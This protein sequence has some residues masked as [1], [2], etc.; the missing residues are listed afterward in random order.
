MAKGARKKTKWVSLSLVSATATTI[1]ATENETDDKLKS[2]R[3]RKTYTAVVSGNSAASYFVA[4]SSDFGYTASKDDTH[5]DEESCD[6]RSQKEFEGSSNTSYS[7]CGRNPYY[8]KSRYLKNNYNNYHSSVK[9]YYIGSSSYIRNNSYSCQRIADAKNDQNESVRINE[10]EYT[11]ITT[12][13][14]DVLFKKGYLSRPKRYTTMNE[15]STLASSAFANGTTDGSDTATGSGSVST[16]ESVISDITYL[17]EG[18]F[19]EYP[20]PY[21]YFGYFD[22]SG[23]LVMNGFAVDNHGYSYMNGGQTYI[24]PPN[25]HCTA[26]FDDA[27]LVDDKHDKM[28][29][30]QVD[31]T[32][33][34]AKETQPV[35]VSNTSN[36]SN[37]IADVDL[38]ENV[39]TNIEYNDPSS[40]PNDEISLVS[41]EYRNE[42]NVDVKE[43]IY[44]TLEPT[45]PQIS[46]ISPYGNGYDYA[47]FYNAFYYPGCV[48]APFPIV[49]D[50]M[51]YDQVGVLSEEEYA[52]QSSFKKRKKLC[53]NWEEYPMEIHESEMM[54]SGCSSAEFCNLE[55]DM[56]SVVEVP[57]NDVA[58]ESYSVLLH[59]SSK[60]IIVQDT[61]PIHTQSVQSQAPPPKISSEYQPSKLE[62]SEDLSQ[63]S[64]PST[65]VS[66]KAR[67][68][69]HPQKLRKRDLIESTLTFAEQNIDLT[70][71]VSRESGASKLTAVRQDSSSL[72]RTVRKGKE[73]VVEEDL[74]LRFIDTSAMTKMEAIH[75]IPEASSKD[76]R[77][78]DVIN[79]AEFSLS[80]IT[81]KRD[82]RGESIGKKVKKTA[83]G[84]GKKQKK[85]HLL[86]Q[87]AGF[88]VIEPKFSAPL[89]N[90]A[91]LNAKS[92][93][94]GELDSTEKIVL[95][96]QINEVNSFLS[97]DEG[98]LALSTHE[99]E[100]TDEVN[101]FSSTTEEHNILRNNVFELIIG[102]DTIA[103]L[104][105]GIFNVQ[106]EDICVLPDDSCQ[107]D[108]PQL[109]CVVDNESCSPSDA[110]KT[111]T[112]KISKS[113]Q[114]SKTM[115][116]V[117]SFLKP[118]QNESK[119]N[120]SGLEEN[121][122][123]NSTLLE[124]SN[125]PIPSDT[126]D[127]DIAYQ[128]D[129][130]VVD[131]HDCKHFSE[132]SYSENYDSG[133][134][135]PTTCIVS[136]NI[137]EER[138]EPSSS[139]SDNDTNLTEAVIN[140]LSE[141]LRN[142]R[143]DEMFVLPEDPTLLHR[144]HQFNVMNSDDSL[145][146]SSDTYSSTSADETEDADSD[147]MSDVQI[148][149][150]LGCN[151][152]VYED[153]QKTE[154]QKDPLFVKQTANDHHPTRNGDH[155]NDKQ[156]RCIIM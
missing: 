5:R 6:D 56:L 134:Q 24:Y 28:S 30:N 80:N 135:S 8:H 27:G 118:V 46:V 62:Q 32:I 79:S 97:V 67:T 16:A 127:R 140:W 2:S 111:N 38:L 104:E 76:G 91:E 64:N 78:H 53:R 113:N 142:K 18:Q 100:E 87:Q 133:L 37:S 36:N 125:D 156:K 42:P 109:Q 131:Q 69:L 141:N 155:F 45:M 137:G 107:H 39:N 144:M 128:L 149:K 95:L 123:V 71:S 34:L 17:T 35:D 19:M 73:I 68:A 98:N 103:N 44:E 152:N 94:N 96:E 59:S 29:P 49:D 114:E 52:K 60:P 21:P 117:P 20:T 150:H 102:E 115:T 83:K 143:L 4:N 26:P 139:Y 47:Q 70:K 41:N 110:E 50:A 153:K 55:P 63:I 25:Y 66:R 116:E 81:V 7:S 84:K 93:L 112:E 90:V 89:K 11:K 86:Q 54:E 3:G 121:L 12:P 10:D 61:S 31:S 43:V 145:V 65:G 1:S 40:Q 124:T 154:S 58:S 15:N 77:K 22:Q 85:F 108:D 106:I 82:K 75:E 129:E 148:K 74:E 57:V 126:I 23:V 105:R 88:E 9:P 101:S 51:Y 48:V 92:K 120:G 132:M 138:K 151:L 14:Q 33:S 99:Q 72:W 130:A 122:I 146:L 119:A 13:R 147:Y 136:V